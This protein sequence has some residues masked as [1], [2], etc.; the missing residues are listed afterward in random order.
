[1]GCCGGKKKKKDGEEDEGDGKCVVSPNAMK[2]I[3]LITLLVSDFDII[4]TSEC[5][6]IALRA[7]REGGA[8]ARHGLHEPEP[9]LDDLERA[10]REAE[11]AGTSQ[12]RMM[13]DP[14]YAEPFMKRCSEKLKAARK[15]QAGGP[16][17]GKSRSRMLG[18]DV[19]GMADPNYTPNATKTRDQMEGRADDAKKVD[20]EGLPGMDEGDEEDFSKKMFDDEIKEDSGSRQRIKIVPSSAICGIALPPPEVK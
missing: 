7:E 8:D 6:A 17:M 9:A 16:N 10:M 18:A 1:M 13:G 2:L 4:F 3:T 19:D 20:P 15:A 11:M 14:R 12:M 5:G